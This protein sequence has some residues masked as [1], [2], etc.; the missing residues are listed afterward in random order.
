[1]GTSPVVLDDDLTS[2]IWRITFVRRKAVNK[3]YKMLLV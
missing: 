1:M 3:A 2:E